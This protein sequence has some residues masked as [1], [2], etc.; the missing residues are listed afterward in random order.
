MICICNIPSVTMI[1]CRWMLLD[2]SV[3]TH[4]VP[5]FTACNRDQPLYTLLTNEACR[6]HAACNGKLYHLKKMQIC[7]F[8]AYS[9]K[10][11]ISMVFFFSF[12][13]HQS[14]LG[15]QSVSNW[16]WITPPLHILIYKGTSFPL[17][18]TGCVS[19]YYLQRLYWYMQ[20]LHWIKMIKSRHFK[21][22]AWDLI[23]WR[24]P[25]F[26]LWRPVVWMQSRFKGSQWF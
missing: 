23:E 22:M 17:V 13:K 15:K 14:S 21:R 24:C 1:C 3:W 19:S 20:C 26:N 6:I 11:I 10:T 7:W 16:E 2:S 5:S 18:W 12:S 25:C 4:G 9:V 8:S